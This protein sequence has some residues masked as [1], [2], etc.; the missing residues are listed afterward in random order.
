MYSKWALNCL[1]VLCC[2]PSFSD[3]SLDPD[4]A[5]CADLREKGVF[6]HATNRLNWGH[7]VNADDFAT[8]HLNNELWELERNRWDWEQ[9]YLHANYST[10]LEE[11]AEIKQPCPDVY[12][13]P[14]VTER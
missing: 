10:S 1:F 4:M 3:R 13:F 14:M 2:R 7:L 5:V 6:L 9:R 12:W 11:G 8:D